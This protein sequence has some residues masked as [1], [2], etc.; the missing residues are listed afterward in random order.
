MV[1]DG[2]GDLHFGTCGKTSLGVEVG[3]EAGSRDQ[4]GDECTSAKER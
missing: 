1:R 2:L 4:V 3:E